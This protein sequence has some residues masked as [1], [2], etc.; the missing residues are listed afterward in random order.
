MKSVWNKLVYSR[1]KNIYLL[2]ALL[3]LFMVSAFTFNLNSHKILEDIAITFVA[4]TGIFSFYTRKRHLYFGF[5]LAFL[6][7]VSSWFSHAYGQSSFLNSILFVL[8]FFIYLFIFILKQLFSEQEV[9]LNTIVGT[10]NGFIILGII[11]GA[12]FLLIDILY[13]NAYIYTHHDPTKFL[14]FI[15]FGFITITTLG[16]GDIV[17]VMPPSQLIII[18]FSVFGQLYLATVIAS[19][20]GKFARKK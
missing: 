18:I 16:Y 1:H 13:D 5:F 9:N 4:I 19:F 15:Y 8:I 2:T 6:T 10:I 20:I 14:T 17:P 3:I 11:A 12:S 7:I